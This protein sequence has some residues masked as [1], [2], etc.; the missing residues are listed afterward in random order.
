MLLPAA[1]GCAVQVYGKDALL[2][3]ARKSA[4]RFS[5]WVEGWSNEMLF[6]AHTTTRRDDDDRPEG[7]GDLLSWKK[8]TRWT[9]V[10]DEESE[11]PEVYISV[12]SVVWIVGLAR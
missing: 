7:D 10:R 11:K 3:L 12:D 9:R 1:V 6:D 4:G 2:F 8:L 5:R